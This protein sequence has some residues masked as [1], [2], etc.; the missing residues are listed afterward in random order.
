MRIGIDLDNTIIR[1][2]ALF[3]AL[4]LERGL[5]DRTVGRTKT[6]IRDHLRRAGREADWTVLQGEA[7]GPSLVGAI[8][9]PGV[10][11]F[12]HRCRAADIPISIISHKTRH[13]ARGPRHDL[14]EAAHRWLRTHDLGHIPTFL[15]PTREAK[16][17]RIAE[18]RCTHFIDDLPEF[19]DSPGFPRHAQRILFD[20]HSHHPSAACDD[21]ITS[22]TGL[23]ER[24]GIPVASSCP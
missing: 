23:S 7:Y 4:A 14:H 9:S 6:A 19:L 16:L 22:F 13:P 10:T 12:I 18:Q 2:D 21:R 8:P 24:L 15:E 3:H 11:A 20:P 1:Y 17:A 5:I